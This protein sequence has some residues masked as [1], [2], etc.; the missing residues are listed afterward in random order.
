MFFQIVFEPIM[1]LQI[2]GLFFIRHNTCQIEI[3]KLDV[4]QYFHLLYFLPKWLFFQS[5]IVKLLIASTNWFFPTFPQGM[6]K[7]GKIT[8][9][10]N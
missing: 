10:S 4:G 3:G 8:I 7:I 9:F 6:L 1:L 2:G 5:P